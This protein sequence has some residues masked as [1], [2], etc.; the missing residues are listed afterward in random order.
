MLVTPE[1]VPLEVDIAGLGSRALATIVDWLIQAAMM[2][3]LF[4]VVGAFH[5]QGATGVAALSFGLFMSFFGYYI[6]FEGLW[7]GQT[8][9]KRT[10]RIRVVKIDGQPATFGP[11]FIRNILRIVDFLPTYYAIGVISIAVTSHSQR[12]G[13]LAAGT[14][15]V[16]EHKTV[17]PMSLSIP[18]PPVPVSSSG[19]MLD[20][21]GMTEAHYSLVRSFLQRR[22]TL[23][24]PARSSL[25][26]QV[27]AA[28]RPVV[29]SGLPLP[30][31]QDEAFIE[32]VAAAYQ[33]RFR[34]AF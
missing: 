24:G 28:I 2:W 11:I 1:A 6:A 5:L 20:T 19:S 23:A 12:I 27:A 25:A 18:P 7:H 14:M 29:H 30:P 17:I 21:T 32:A 13:D 3:L 33:S 31:G 26:A 10:Q 8:P 15:V 4:V 9:G 16:R 34:G 22:D